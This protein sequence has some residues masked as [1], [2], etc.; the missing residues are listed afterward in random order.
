MSTEDPQLQSVQ[1]ILEEFCRAYMLERE[2]ERLRREH[3]TAQLRK[4]QGELLS[5]LKDAKGFPRPPPRAYPGLRSFTSREAHL[6]FGR[7]REASELRNRLARSNVVVVLG[8]SGSGKSSLVLAGV[9]PSLND[10]GQI[11][12]RT[13]RWYTATFRPGDDPCKNITEAIWNDVCVPLLSARGGSQAFIES[14]NVDTHQMLVNSN[15]EALSDETQKSIK[16]RVINVLQPGGTFTAD[17]LSLFLEKLDIIDTRLAEERRTFRSGKINF[18]LLADQFEE[19]FRDSVLREKEA[20]LKAI[21]DVL[22]YAKAHQQG[23][24]VVVAT[25]RSEELHRCS[26]IDKL[27]ELINEGFY[28]IG[29]PTFQNLTEATIKPGRQTLRDWGVRPPQAIENSNHPSTFPFSED[30]VAKLKVWTERFQHDHREQSF[31]P[32]G[33]RRQQADLLPLFQHLL[34]IIWGVAIERWSSETDKLPTVEVADIE[35]WLKNRR[36]RVLELRKWMYGQTVIKTARRTDD[37]DDLLQ[38]V[39]DTGFAITLSDA[40]LGEAG[41]PA[42]KWPTTVTEDMSRRY[43]L[44]RAAFTALATRDA[45]GNDARRPCSA[46]EILQASNVG[47]NEALLRDVLSYFKDRNYVRGGEG[48]QKYDVTHEAL[49][50]NSTEYQIWLSEAQ[51][52]YAALRESSA[53]LRVAG[54]N[55]THDG[56]GVR[57][58]IRNVWSNFWLKPFSQAAQRLSGDRCRDLGKIFGPDAVF[59]SGW[60]AQRA[61]SGLENKDPT[62]EL[63]RIQEVW[64]KASRWRFD[65]SLGGKH[66]QTIAERLTAKVLRLLWSLRSDPPV[67]GRA[68]WTARAIMSSLLVGAAAVSI[69]WKVWYT[70]QQNQDLDE[71]RGV[72]QVLAVTGDVAYPR[73]QKD[74]ERALHHIK[75]IGKRLIDL[76]PKIEGSDAKRDLMVAEATFDG[77]VRSYLKQTFLAEENTQINTA[78][79]ELR[80]IRFN[81]G[82]SIGGYDKIV[83]QDGTRQFI[84]NQEE[85]LIQ[86][87]RRLSHRLKPMHRKDGGD[88]ISA[89]LIPEETANPLFG[90]TIVCGGDNLDYLLVWSQLPS[91]SWP[92]IYPVIW[93]EL[94]NQMYARIDEPYGVRSLSPKVSEILTKMGRAITDNALTPKETR[95]NPDPLYPDYFKVTLMAGGADP[96]VLMRVSSR[97][98]DP[99][100]IYFARNI[101]FSIPVPPPTK[102]L[103]SCNPNNSPA[104]KGFDPTSICGSGSNEVNNL[105]VKLYSSAFDRDRRSGVGD[106]P[107]L[108]DATLC[109]HRVVL[110]YNPTAAVDGTLVDI[111]RTEITRV[112]APSIRSAGVLNDSLILEDNTSTFRAVPVNTTK[113]LSILS[114]LPPHWAEEAEPTTICRLFACKTWETAKQ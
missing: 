111:S 10:I 70:S 16:R 6:F 88:L 65:F 8:G 2:V 23:A 74:N 34:R 67:S 5:L 101:N 40:I 29:R 83:S 43:N 17:G 81:G 41:R 59:E 78:Q 22:T 18:L 57:S 79:Y 47:A 107:C 110:S 20:D 46:S 44:I 90:P 49:I 71:N 93:F 9:L 102:K 3:K 52:I 28:L 109:T 42:S 37:P 95:D 53:A 69:G 108:P 82:N 112:I 14:F 72:L 39:F 98:V 7:R 91:V 104:D 24:L 36:S 21:V 50:R 51:K 56:S 85:E 68:L 55:H 4:I 113:L 96:W 35:L 66:P 103:P 62:E 61:E 31:D 87:S 86:G 64:E 60:I 77:A 12:G 13:G 92:L 106:A 97:D 11:A 33:I 80:C 58:W 54:G 27:S 15:D 105:R 38:S 100:D 114:G 19:I 76:L 73:Q 1:G 30:F 48:E 75:L 84:V 63:N 26:E 94:D 32:E 45:K 99:F 89:E 25:L